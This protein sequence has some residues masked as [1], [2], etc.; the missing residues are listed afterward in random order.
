MAGCSLQTEQSCSIEFIV[1]ELS[2]CVCGL[3]IDPINQSTNQPV[4]TTGFL[5]LQGT[6]A[7]HLPQT[8]VLSGR[9][10]K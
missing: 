4:T 10:E 8:W 3:N 9:S 2:A 6:S 7:A 1:C 5:K